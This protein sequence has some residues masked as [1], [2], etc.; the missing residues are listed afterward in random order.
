MEKENNIVR[1]ME[2]IC[3]ALALTFALGVVVSASE[4]STSEGESAYSLE[5]D[6][7]SSFVMPETTHFIEL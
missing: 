3:T 4:A 5:Y 6:S 2:V 1:S 7:N